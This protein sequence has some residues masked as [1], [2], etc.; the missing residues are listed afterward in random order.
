MSSKTV[1]WCLFFS[2]TGCLADNYS[3][4]L[5]T[6]GWQVNN[7]SAFC[8]LTQKIPSLGTADFFHQSGD[9][10]Q[11]SLIEERFKPDIVKAS[12]TVHGAAWQ[13]ES[14]SH[15][16]YLV[17]L[18]EAS[19][20]HNYPR[21]SVYGEIAEIMFDVLQKG[22]QP[23]F[24]YVRAS[25]SGFS[26]ET[27]VAISAI[28]FA[29]TYQQ[30]NDCRKNFFPFG[31]KDIL[32]KSLFFK[33]GSSQFNAAVQAQI[34]STAEYVNEVKGANIVI[35]SDTAIAGSRD[36]NWFMKRANSISKQL[37]KLGV[38]QNKIA[39]KNGVYSKSLNNNVIQ[40]SVF[41]PDALKSIY[42]RKG[43]TKL[44]VGE[45]Q[46]LNLLLQYRTAFLP[47]SQFVIKSHTDGKGKRAKNLKVSQQRGDVIKQYLVSQGVDEKQIRVKAY[48]ESK[49]VKSNRFPRG[50]SQNRRAVIELEG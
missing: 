12:L 14:I 1:L 50:R 8:Q 37:K 10:L 11:F 29:K 15:K 35:V 40:L 42:Y 44:T 22:Q 48:G 18:E 19:N 4:P 41:G 47:Q 2:S 34:N 21:L 46:R 6:A 9:Q 32:E 43:N 23:T 38:A 28:N 33:Q 45:Q 5:L 39:I 49:P 20:L 7:G 31:F 26:P 24:T 30:F 27:N 13:H 25:L 16:D 17:T 3:V 36:K